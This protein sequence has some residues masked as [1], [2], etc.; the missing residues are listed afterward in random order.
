MEHHTIIP[1]KLMVDIVN[2]VRQKLSSTVC[3]DAQTMFLWFLLNYYNPNIN[4]RDSI[5][6]EIDN[7]DDISLF[8]NDLN[9]YGFLTVVIE[10][11]NLEHAFVLVNTENGVHIVDSYVLI[12]CISYRK[13]DFNMLINLRSLDDWNRLF[14]ANEESVDINMDNFIIR[15]AYYL[16]K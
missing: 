11:K 5:K 12:R 10:W 15:Y 6:Y 13:F 7:V 8:I 2:Q 14:M 9:S 3:D 1:Y 4:I 16:L